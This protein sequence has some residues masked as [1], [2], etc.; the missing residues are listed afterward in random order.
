MLYATL[1]QVNVPTLGCPYSYNELFTHIP[2][3]NPPKVNG[4][5]SWILQSGY[6]GKPSIPILELVEGCS[7]LP[8]KTVIQQ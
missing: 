1:A 4:L 6:F 7:R 3:N 8:R 2:D 5:S